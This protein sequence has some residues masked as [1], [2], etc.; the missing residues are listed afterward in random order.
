MVQWFYMSRFGFDMVLCTTALVEQQPMAKRE[1][2]KVITMLE[3]L[4]H[5]RKGLS[6]QGHNFSTDS[7]R[8]HNCLLGLT[9]YMVEFVESVAFVTT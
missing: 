4:S 5:R 6:S 9:H 7:E 3:K 1:T 8:N 2:A